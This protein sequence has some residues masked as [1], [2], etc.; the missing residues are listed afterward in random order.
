MSTKTSTVSPTAKLELYLNSFKEITPSDLELISIIASLSVILITRPSITSRSFTKPTVP[1]KAFS[2]SFNL[3]SSTAS[4]P[5]SYLCQLKFFK[6]SSCVSSFATG[7]VSVTSTVSVDSVVAST[8]T[9]CTS[10]ALA[11]SVFFV[12]SDMLKMFLYLIVIQII[13][14]KN[15]KRYY[16]YL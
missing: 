15:S 11:A 12:S 2:N 9:S 14:D 8:A 7:V 5:S 13:N 10:G 6:K 4:I 3:D 16:T 1:S